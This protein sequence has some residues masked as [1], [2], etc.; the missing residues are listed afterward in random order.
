[1]LAHFSFLIHFCAVRIK[2]GIFL[3]TAGVA[4]MKN[5]RRRR[6]RLGVEALENR[7][8]LSALTVSTNWAGYA[9]E[10]NLNAPQA[11]SVSAVSGTWIVSAVTGRGAPCAS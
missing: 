1:M 2:E 10:T 9:V 11:G 5:Q 7:L 8:A 4:P 6:V 3:G